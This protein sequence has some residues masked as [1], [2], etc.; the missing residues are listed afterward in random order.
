MTAPMEPLARSLKKDFFS[1]INQVLRE[2]GQEELSAP[3]Q[4]LLLNATKPE[5]GDYQC[6]QAMAL[7][8]PLRQAPLSIAELIIQNLPDNRD[9]EA[10]A[11]KPGFI[12]IRLDEG[13]LV[14]RAGELFGDRE[15]LGVAPVDTP[16]RVI[17]DYSSP[18]IAK[19]MHVG[20]L[21]STIIGESIARVLEF[22]GHHVS[23]VNHVGDWGT[24]FGMLIRELK[25]TVPDFGEH[26]PA[27]LP[28]GDLVEFYKKAKR[29][30]D[31]DDDF[32]TAARHEVT[33]L[34]SGNPESLRAWEILCDISRR[35]FREIYDLL[36]VDLEEK[37][38]SFYNPWLPG[39]LEEM[40]SR[41]ILETSDG[42]KCVFV[43]GIENRDAELLPL[44]LQKGDGGYTYDT[45][46]MAALRY[47]LEKEKA[48][49]IYYVTDAGQATHFKLVFGAA[50]RAGWLD[51]EHT[52]RHI[53][54]GLVLGEDRK[55]FRTRAGET[56]R[57][58]DLLEEATE[59]AAAIVEEK[60]PDLSVEQQKRIARVLGIGAVKYSDLSQNR[61]NDYVFSFDK[62]LQL[63][64]N[65]APYM[66][67]A[68]V[69]VKSIFRR[70]GVD[71]ES[72][73]WP[74]QVAELASEERALL[75]QINRFPEVFSALTVDF[76]THHLA[77]YLFDLSQFFSR[78][79]KNC[80]VLHADNEN[81]RQFRLALARVTAD[82]LERGLSL[83]G[84]S[85]VE[86][87]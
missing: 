48:S 31:E 39:V 76:A 12:N 25:D 56:V 46:D 79:Y 2:A 69:R 43:E 21:R 1:A 36:E 82:I 15:R 22:A 18:N 3:D 24:Q 57:L 9:Y 86:V 83:L 29:H 37:G 34:Q 45:T 87:M 75:L 60:N 32:K 84:I 33:E 67:Y 72:L 51:E 71:P 64:G 66:I 13:L 49:D 78:F 5:F 35:S 61:I 16:R 8:K 23:R 59:R 62:M 38:E 68:V 47:R 65:T 58:L 50:R 11:V 19:E 17:V 70:G 73:E 4:V 74:A 40:E 81:T 7:A 42:A 30:F 55:K 53:P 26:G 63:Q 6:N 20:H 52:I 28:I 85:V 80:P 54:F 14:E 77:E 27:S 44:M 41:G 10:T